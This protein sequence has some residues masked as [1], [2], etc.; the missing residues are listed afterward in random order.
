[1][2]CHCV[3]HCSVLETQRLEDGSHP[4]AAHSREHKGPTNTWQPEH[5][6]VQAQMTAGRTGRK[7]PLSRNTAEPQR[8]GWVRQAGTGLSRQKGDTFEAQRCEE[9]RGAVITAAPELLKQEG[10][11]TNRRDRS[12]LSPWVTAVPRKLGTHT[13]H[14]T[15]TIM[16]QSDGAEQAMDVNIQGATQSEQEEIG[17]SGPTGSPNTGPLGSMKEAVSRSSPTAL[18]SW[19]KAG[20]AGRRGIPFCQAWSN[21]L[22]TFPPWRVLGVKCWLAPCFESFDHFPSPLR[23]QILY[24][25]IWTQKRLQSTRPDDKETLDPAK[26]F[27]LVCYR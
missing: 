10:G 12:P 9:T 11:R 21:A 17:S 26:E 2:K 15:L 24:R 19:R 22:L 6:L 14:F 3:K 20:W 18:Q 25:C 1:M 7:P 16:A 27:M 13:T 23:G 4:Q 5:F 8:G